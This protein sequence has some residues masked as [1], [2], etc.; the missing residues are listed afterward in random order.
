MTR[1]TTAR[2]TA[3]ALAAAAG[4]TL[5]D[6]GDGS[7]GYSGADGAVENRGDGSGTINDAGGSRAVPMD[8]LSPLP[9]VGKF[10]PVKSIKPLGKYCGTLIRLKDRLLFDFDNAT[11]RPAAADVLDRL[12]PALADVQGTL[13]VNGHTDSLG[14]DTY[15]LDL[16][17]RRVQA[18]VDALKERRVSAPMTPTGFGESQPIAPNTIGG[19]DHPAGRRLNRRVEIIVPVS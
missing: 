6:R 4:M 1:R 11:L 12:A 15:N 14:S 5:T 2:L 18:V 8:P 9:K 10:P 13:K 17:R 16:S 19:K 7:G 3:L